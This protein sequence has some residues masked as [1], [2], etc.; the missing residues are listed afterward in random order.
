[1]PPYLWFCFLWCQSPAANCILKCSMGKSGNQQ[2]LS[3]KLHAHLSSVMK[4]LA[5]PLPCLRCESSLCL[6]C[7]SVGHLVVISVITLTVVVTVL[8][9]KSPLFYLIAVPKLK[10]SDASNLDM[11]RRSHR[12]FPLSEKV[13]VL[14]L[15]RKK[16]CMLKLLRWMVRMNL[17][18]M[19][20]WRTKRNLC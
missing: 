15:I 1:M 8:M 12:V 13:E 19:K 9:F 7:P 2:F 5:N 6:V 20:L 16:N 11:P 3:F 4:S 14:S 18:A 17:L 10:N